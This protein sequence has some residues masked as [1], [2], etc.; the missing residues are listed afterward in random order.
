MLA[1]EERTRAHGLSHR[2]SKEIKKIPTEG[3]KLLLNT[4]YADLQ[5]KPSPLNAQQSG[6]PHQ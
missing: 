6:N 2:K 3:I 4:L 1:P 5:M